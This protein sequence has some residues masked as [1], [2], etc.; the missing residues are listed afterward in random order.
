[1]SALSL[2][3]DMLSLSGGMLLLGGGTLTTSGNVST[4][5]V[6]SSGLSPVAPTGNG[7][8]EFIDFASS[9]ELCP[10]SS[11][12]I[13]LVVERG[14]GKRVARGPAGVGQI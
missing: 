2:G 8:D 6:F 7:G 9:S 13:A 1:M 10:A 14:N 5:I 12:D 4:N 11:T 3:D